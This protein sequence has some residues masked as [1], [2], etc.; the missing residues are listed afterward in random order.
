M[1]L[2]IASLMVIVGSIA[3]ACKSPAH[4]QENRPI[5]VDPADYDLGRVLFK[6]KQ[7]TSAEEA[8]QDASV[9]AS[10]LD[11]VVKFLTHHAELRIEVLGFADEKECDGAECKNLAERRALAVFKWLQSHGVPSNQLKGHEGFGKTQPVDLSDTEAQRQ[12]NRRAEFKVE[13]A[14]SGS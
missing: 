3:V 13:V 2:W 12:N 9:N 10:S 14:K 5:L 11:E 6:E 7:P 1:N 4:G 8:L